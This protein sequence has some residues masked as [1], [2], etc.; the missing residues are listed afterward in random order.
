MNINIDMLKAGKG[1]VDDR[2]YDNDRNYC[3]QI[4]KIDNTTGDLTWRTG[5][6]YHEGNYKNE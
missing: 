6:F 4:T 2:L 5:I 1:Q 3:G